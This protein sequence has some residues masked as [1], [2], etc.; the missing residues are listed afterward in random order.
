M[1]KILIFSIFVFSLTSY[2]Q[3]KF[4]SGYV[5]DNNGT[6]LNCLINNLDWRS[7]PTEFEYKVSLNS[8]IK[9]GNYR[10][11]LEFGFDQG[12]KFKR[13]EIEI[14]RSSIMT[15]SLSKNADPEYTTEV[16][17]LKQILEGTANLFL[18]KDGNIIKYFFST[19]SLELPKQLIYKKYTVY[20]EK[21]GAD[22]VFENNNYQSQLKS[23]FNCENISS[24]YY[25]KIE[26]KK[27]DLLN[28]FKKYD[29]CNGTTSKTIES[30]TDRK[31][32][33]FNI[34][35]SIRSSQL[36]INNPSSTIHEVSFDKKTS[37]SLGFEFEY[38]LP[39]NNGK[40]SIIAE[41]TIQ[42]YK[43]EKEYNYIFAT[44]PITTIRSTTATVEYKSIELPIGLRHYMFL[45][46]KSKLFINLVYSLDFNNSDKKIEY[47]SASIVDLDIKTR[48]NLGFGFGYNFDNKYSIEFRSNS[49][50]EILGGYA[51]FNGNYTS[52]SIILGVNI[53]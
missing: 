17:F 10:D 38:I 52:S 43:N 14:D 26:Y 2:S 11:V 3:N 36:S 34:R 22:N 46:D 41:P 25:K 13:F 39:F 15:K 28:F 12:V 44:Q 53:F 31:E 37:F 29:E 32:F 30:N 49:K 24:D 8:D 20:N 23:N 51:L 4:Q 19:N 9:T 48:N 1:K 18:Y 42:S 5:I 50:R 33:Y 27:N 45:N 16:L 21:I 40:W 35:P 7:N 6:K 47:E